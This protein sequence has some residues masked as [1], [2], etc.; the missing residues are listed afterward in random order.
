MEVSMDIFALLK[1][2][3]INAL[4]SAVITVIIGFVLVLNPEQ[5]TGTICTLI[6]WGLLIMGVFGLLNHFVFNKE[7]SNLLDLGIAL[8]ETIAGFY[9]ALNPTGLVKVVA[10]VMAVVLLVHGFHDVDLALQMK[11]SGYEKWWGTALIAALMVALGL[12]TLINP[13]WPTNLLLRILGVSLL[14][15]GASELFIIHRASK[16]IDKAKPIDVEAK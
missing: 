11:R 12:L 5:V 3:K 6:G 15:D 13:F 2:I 1:K 9:I 14:C 10:A 8:I 16:V 4:A 7:M